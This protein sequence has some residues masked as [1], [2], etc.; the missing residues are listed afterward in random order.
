MVNN[1]EKREEQRKK[2]K[3]EEEQM[4]TKEREESA[5]KGN[6]SEKRKKPER[7]KSR[8]GKREESSEQREAKEDLTRTRR[9]LV[10]K[11]PLVLLCS[12]NFTVNIQLAR[13]KENQEKR[14]KSRK[15]EEALRIREGERG[16][17]LLFESK[18]TKHGEAAER[19]NHR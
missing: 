14:T 15:G 7:R 19:L 1:R 3:R 4:A 8:K 2:I 12:P 16:R 13:K 9:R 18:K 11:S 6:S 17:L 10:E 5:K